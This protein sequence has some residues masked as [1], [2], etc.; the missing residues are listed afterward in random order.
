MSKPYPGKFITEAEKIFN[1]MEK[2][3]SW[4]ELNP[5]AIKISA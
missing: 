5:Q 4:D 1:D 3:P 2:K